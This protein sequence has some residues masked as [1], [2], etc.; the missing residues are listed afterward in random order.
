MSFGRETFCMTEIV[1]QKLHRFIGGKVFY[2]GLT[3]SLSILFTEKWEF[4]DVLKYFHEIP[5]ENKTHYIHFDFHVISREIIV[6]NSR[7]VSP[8]W[9]LYK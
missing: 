6:W 7:R 9:K 1:A 3:I 2:L 5:I 4:P 8:S